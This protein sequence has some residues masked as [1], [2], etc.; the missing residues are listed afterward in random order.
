M[1]AVEYVAG[2]FVLVAASYIFI[3]IG[4]RIER[5]IDP[6]SIIDFFDGIRFLFF[7]MGFLFALLALNFGRAV[8]AGTTTDM[9]NIFDTTITTYTYGMGIL[10]TLGLAYFFIIIPKALAKIKIENRRKEEEEAANG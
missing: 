9:T 4:F 3:D 2:A 6:G 1:T 10:F 8:V 7:A 5:K